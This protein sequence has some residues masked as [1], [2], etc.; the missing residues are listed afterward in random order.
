MISTEICPVC[1]E[2]HLIKSEQMASFEID[3][4]KFDAEHHFHIC[5]LC[6]TEVATSEDLKFNARS[7]KSAELH[8]L[9]RMNGDDIKLFRKNLKI[10][11]EVA[12]LLFGGGPIAFCKYEKHDL[13][14]TEAM[15]NL[16]WIAS[17]FPFV[18]DALA[19]RH[20]IELPRK[21][22]EQPSINHNVV[23]IDSRPVSEF[24][25][26]KPSA[27]AETRKMWASIPILM[28]SALPAQNDY[29]SNNETALAA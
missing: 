10:S 7:F 25:L 8:A 19:S 16:L 21:A 20:N 17:K 13:A 15:D 1:C 24:M 28:G 2:G 27:Q 18:V 23:N 5:D 6:A 9:G 4:N 14:P 26:N 22:I 11:Q 29:S 3:Q 12:A